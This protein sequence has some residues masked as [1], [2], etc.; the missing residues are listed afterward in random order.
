[1]HV[2]HRVAAARPETADE[3]VTLAMALAVRAM[4]NGSVCLDL[5]AVR[6]RSARPELPW[7]A[8]TSGLPRLR[9]SPLLAT[10]PVLRLYGDRLLYLDR[11]WLEEEQVCE[12]L[13]GALAPTHRRCGRWRPDWIGCSPTRLR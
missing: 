5:A 13:L 10:P 7:P 11:Y 4:R 12:E 1:M 9:A 6:I 3:T 2:A 8:P